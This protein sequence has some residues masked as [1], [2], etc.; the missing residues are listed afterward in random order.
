MFNHVNI[1][2]FYNCI[3]VISIFLLIALEYVMLPIERRQKILDCVKLRGAVSINDLVNILAVSH[4][5]VRRDLEKLEH[6]GL[7]VSVSGGVQISKKL[8]TEPSRIAKAEMAAVEK[9][10]IGRYATTIIPEGACIYLDAGTTSLALA[11]FL[12]NR[13]DLTIVTNDFA[14]LNFLSDNGMNNVIHTGGQLRPQNM[15]AVG[16]LAARNIESLNFDIAFLSASSWDYRGITT[17]DVDKVIVK[18][19]AV[20]SAR[21]KVLICDSSKY[22]QVATYVAV[23]LSELDMMI[24]DSALPDNARE[25]LQSNH[26]EVKLV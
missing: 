17:P 18:Q 19:A 26:I 20:K 6:E 13:E 4:M 12:T 9:E 2:V 10:R 23:K 7:V 1:C 25:I 5:T 21:R 11:H 8:S 16:L 15:S 22:S 3:N 24:T 14:V